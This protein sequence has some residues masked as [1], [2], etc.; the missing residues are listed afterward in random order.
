[1]HR[2]ASG[3]SGRDFWG[4]FRKD[5]I[6]MFGDFLSTLLVYLVVLVIVAILLVL[7]LTKSGAFGSRIGA[8]TKELKRKLF[9]PERDE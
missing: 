8:H 4:L 3:F 1:L 6:S 9:S 5:I 2:E 7:L